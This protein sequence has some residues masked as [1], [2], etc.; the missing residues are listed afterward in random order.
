MD[1]STNIID[2]EYLTNPCYTIKIP[3]KKKNQIYCT[4]SEDLN[5]YKKRIFGL[6]RKM[7]LGGNINT[8]VNDAFHGWAKVCIE[9]FKFMDKK[10]II[11]E[12][13]KD[14]PPR[15]NNKPSYFNMEETNKLFSKQ[16]TYTD[17]ATLMNIR[18][19]TKPIFMPTKR[20]IN[21]KTDVLKNKGVIYSPPI[22]N[23]LTNK[24]EKTNK[25][26]KKKKKK[27]KEK[28]EDKKKRRGKRKNCIKV[29]L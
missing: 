20:N 1:V 28:K 25:K 26:K 13:Y 15:K 19:K 6:T 17:I 3:E 23:N 29:E 16:Q 7:L 22:K 21:L 2:L 9:H 8:K 12:D 4:S 11:Q 10:D 24:Y 27:K 18:K 5:F 14:I